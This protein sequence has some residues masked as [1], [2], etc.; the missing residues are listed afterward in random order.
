LCY[1]QFG[2][3]TNENITGKFYYCIAGIGFNC[4][5]GKIN[6]GFYYNCV[7][8]NGAFSGITSIGTYINCSGGSGS[9]SGNGG[10]ANGTYINCVGEN[11]S[12]GR[13][14]ASGTFTNCVAGQRSFGAAPDFSNTETV[15]ASGVFTN[16]IGGNLSFGGTLNGTLTGKLHY[17]RLTS[18]TFKTVSSGGRTYYCVDG[19]GN[20]NNQ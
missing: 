6:S 17:C 3:T 18:G 12:F 9:F 7:A 5:S 1:K 13:F 16:C 20:T 11:N 15:T 10:N 8:T 14:S 2:F 4:G 19:N